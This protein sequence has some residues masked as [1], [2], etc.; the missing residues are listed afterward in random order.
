MNRVKFSV[1]NVRRR[2]RSLVRNCAPTGRGAADQAF[3]GNSAVA[4]RMPRGRGR[5]TRRCGSRGRRRRGRPLAAN[6]SAVVGR[7]VWRSLPPGGRPEPIR[8]LQRIAA[9]HGRS[10]ADIPGGPSMRFRGDARAGMRRH[11]H[12]RAGLPIP[13]FPTPRRP[14]VVTRSVLVGRPGP[15]PA[16]PLAPTLRCSRRHRGWPRRLR[17]FGRVGTCR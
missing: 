1:G 4:G 15:H 14:D 13:T 7:Q 5:G 6:R 3:R 2:W 11:D 8:P 12:R 10:A 17:A 9:T 16:R